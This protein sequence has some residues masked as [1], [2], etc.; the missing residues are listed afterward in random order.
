MGQHMHK[1]VHVTIR[2]FCNLKFEYLR[3]NESVGVCVKFIS[4]I[5]SNTVFYWTMVWSTMLEIYIR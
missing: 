5:H 1:D 2:E 4:K 3:E